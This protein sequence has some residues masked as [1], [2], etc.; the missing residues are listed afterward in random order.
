[1]KRINIMKRP[2][3]S[4]LILRVENAAQ[5]PHPE[6]EDVGNSEEKIYVKD[7]DV[8][9]LREEKDV[10]LAIS[11][12]IRVA[13]EVNSGQTI[14]HITLSDASFPI[15]LSPQMLKALAN[16]ECSVE[17]YCDKE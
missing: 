10:Q 12:A 17:I 3:I 8:F 6:M 16:S 5:H 9:L 14:L 2:I 1:M 7:Y 13:S 4:N 11:D 15:C